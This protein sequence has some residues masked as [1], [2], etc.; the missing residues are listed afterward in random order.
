MAVAVA[1]IAILEGED[2][3]LLEVNVA[4]LVAHKVH[5]RKALRNVDTVDAVITSPRSDGRNLV[6]LSGYNY[7]SLILLLRV[8]LFRTI[9]LFLS[10][11]LDLPELY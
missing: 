1:A 7:L 9:H 6:D 4:R 5:L 11:F 3:D 10:L 8:A 2:V